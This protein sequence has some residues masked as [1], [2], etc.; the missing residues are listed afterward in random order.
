MEK[1]TGGSVSY[2]PGCHTAV[3][4]MQQMAAPAKFTL[5]FSPHYYADI[6]LQSQLYTH[7]TFSPP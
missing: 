3:E 6:S 7:F 4:T 5:L 2:L 1:R